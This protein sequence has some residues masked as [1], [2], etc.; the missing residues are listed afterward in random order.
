MKYICT[1]LAL[2]ALTGAARATPQDQAVLRHYAVMAH[3]MYTD[4]LTTAR[5]L[6]RCL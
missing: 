5:A 4:S 2:L 6:G 3:A 1:V